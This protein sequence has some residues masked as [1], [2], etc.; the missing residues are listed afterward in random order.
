MRLRCASVFSASWR[1]GDGNP[2]RGN[3]QQKTGCKEWIPT[4]VGM[5]N[6]E[7]GMTDEAK[8]LILHNSL[9]CIQ[10]SRLNDICQFFS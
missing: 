1:I 10:I 3:T 8:F 9:I 2:Y 4:F 5:K 6:K 7:V